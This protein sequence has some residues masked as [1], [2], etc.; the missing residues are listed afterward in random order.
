MSALL[1]ALLG[2]S[3]GLAPSASGDQAPAALQPVPVQSIRLDDPALGKAFDTNRAYLASF[4]PDRLLLN[5]RRT[6]GLPA[7]G[8]PLGGWEAP[9]C[10]LRGHFVGHYLAA[11]AVTLA[12]RDDPALRANLDRV[13]AGLAA[14]QDALGSGYLSAFPAEFLDRVEAGQQVW[15]PYYTLHKLLAGLLEVHR[16]LGDERALAVARRFGEHLVVRCAAIDDAT[17]ARM[18]G[19]EFGGM[20]EALFD[21]AAATGDERSA[22]LARRFRK[23]SFLQPL[24]RGEDPLP[25]LHANTHL[26]QIEG[27]AR[28]HELG[29]EA[30]PRSAVEAFWGHLRDAHSYA[31]GGSNAGEYWGPPGRLAN[32]L[33]TTNQ[34]FCT[35]Y[36]AWRIGNAL[37]RWTGEA[38]YG[39]DLERL[40]HN[41]LL[42][43]QHPE[44]GMFLYY[45]PLATGH[46]K[47]RGSP[48]DTLTCCYG[49][50]IEAMARLGEGTY[51]RRGDDIVVAQFV[52]TTLEGSSAA[53]GRFTLAQASELPFGP[54][55]TLTFLA[56]ERP[57]ELALVV[58][59]PSWA[60]SGVG[61]AVN[62]ELLG[63]SDARP[64]PRWLE[65]RRRWQAGD[66]VVLT[67]PPSLRIESMP[68]DPTVGAV[69]LGP[70]V[71]AGLV[72]EGEGNDDLPIA[73]LTGDKSAPGTWLHAQPA[74][75]DWRT[76]GMPVERTFRP[77]RDV[78]DERYGVYWPFGS[79][80]GS[81]QK[82]YEAALA[83]R[84]DRERRTIDA[85]L[86]G[87]EASERGH[88]YEGTQ[89][90]TGT[91]NGRR[92]RHAQRGGHLTYR[93]AIDPEAPCVLAVTYSGDDDG[94]R[95]FDLL[96]DGERVASERLAAR[97]PGRFFTAEYAIP[98]ERTR[99][100][101]SVT[102]RIEPAP[103]GAIAGGV[104]GL[105]TLRR[106]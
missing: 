82:A 78:V 65:I 28:H 31:T 99:G 91:F 24:A 13:V 35:S 64:G 30:E 96:V 55:T 102:V 22:A 41:G 23:Q 71:L 45:L 103:N 42:V 63:D 59:I 6:A 26:A 50:G 68:D 73:P 69:L 25:G 74:S 87:D 2:L 32:T 79:P 100:K 40:L 17:F 86:P 16:Q 11:S 15:A 53:L 51:L 43:S 106:P 77:L 85:V 76:S 47:D 12:R 92:W 39:D 4:D 14:C 95:V 83:E 90:E 5:F 88:A 1:T 20:E 38:R 3:L 94:E 48:F 104:Y 49:T 97:A 75:R 93:L 72:G 105:R 81:R 98:P 58:R 44:T 56:V 89:S 70:V 37:L 18:L 7:P 8:Q 101:T 80:G 54:T 84:A 9:D 19:N 60:T 46:R 52:S 36:N 61:V 29:G 67:M 27:E 66:R 34:E 62:G 21:L 33:G 10:E 57:G